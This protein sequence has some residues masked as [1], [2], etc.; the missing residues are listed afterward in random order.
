MK[1]FKHIVI[2]LVLGLGITLSFPALADTTYSFSYWSP[3]SPYPSWYVPLRYGYYPSFYSFNYF[4][5]RYT[6][7]RPE[8]P[9]PRLYNQSLNP[10]LEAL[11]EQR[12]Q[13]WLQEKFASNQGGV[14]L[15][16]ILKQE[17]QAQENPST[18]EIKTEI[19]ETEK[20]LVAPDIETSKPQEK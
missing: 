13:L 2:I 20:P 11:G 1:F 14:A 4:Y 6:Y 18:P 5:P 15:R 19:K 9:T 8:Y 3:Y 16:P 17:K 7:T 12:K 10:T